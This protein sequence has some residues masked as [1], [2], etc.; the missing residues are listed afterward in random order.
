ML[1]TTKQL[2]AEAISS[3]AMHLCSDL[4]CLSTSSLA[5]ATALDARKQVRSLTKQG[6]RA[7]LLEACRGHEDPVYRKAAFVVLC[8]EVPDVV[9]EAASKAP[10]L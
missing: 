7:G 2:L 5:A 4:E 3:V 8:D 9:L 10:I 6:E 1:A